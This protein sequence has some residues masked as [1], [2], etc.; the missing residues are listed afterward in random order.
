MARDEIL[1]FYKRYGIE[2]DTKERES[3]A[4]IGG[5]LPAGDMHNAPRIP[6]ADS[7]VVWKLHP[8]NTMEPVKVSLGITDHAYTEVSAIV[9]GELKEGD[10][11]II[12]SVVTKNQAPGGIGH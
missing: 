9:K 8:D 6:K 3:P 4:A 12:R 10:D 5:T 11:V 1:V 2:E 7:A